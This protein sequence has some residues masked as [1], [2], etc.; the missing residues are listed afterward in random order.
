MF[1]VGWIERLAVGEGSL[2]VVQPAAG[3]RELFETFAIQCSF[4]GAAVGVAAEDD[5]SYL[6]DFYGVFDGGGD[7]VDVI[8]ADGNH[9]ADAAGEEQVSGAGLKDEVWDDAGVRTGDEKTLRGLHFG[10]QVEIGALGGKD[11]PVKTLVTFNQF[12]HKLPGSPK[13][14]FKSSLSHR[15]ISDESWI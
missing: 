6:K 2:D 4:E 8:A 12:I 5:V 15:P 14:A 7:A 11:V 10:E 3:F 9:V 13:N 1:A